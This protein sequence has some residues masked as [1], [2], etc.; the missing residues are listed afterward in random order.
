MTWFVYWTDG[1]DKAEAEAHDVDLPRL[2]EGSC[3]ACG[4]ML[5]HEPMAGVTMG[6][7][8]PY[9]WHLGVAESGMPQVTMIR[10]GGADDTYAVIWLDSTPLVEA[11][12]E[13]RAEAAVS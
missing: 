8:G 10:K 11:L 2:A 7:C 13:I 3:P 4:G 1:I 12:A 5:A 6:R 9:Y